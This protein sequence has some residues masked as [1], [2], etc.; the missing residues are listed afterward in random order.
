[1]AATESWARPRGRGSQQERVIPTV[2][3]VL[4]VPI[5]V[6]YVV[7]GVLSMVLGALYVP[8]GMFS[9]LSLDESAVLWTYGMAV[10][11]VAF[12]WLEY[13]LGKKILAGRRWAWLVGFV[14]QLPALV[15]FG[16]LQWWAPA[17]VARGLPSWRWW[18]ALPTVYCAVVLLLA[19][20]SDI[21]IRAYLRHRE[22]RDAR[23]AGGVAT[24]NA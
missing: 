10:A 3:K 11:L 8:L 20:L 13:Q 7:Q 6:I 24:G 19:I 16:T 12:G 1:M 2:I 5:G 14:L 15:A 9:V 18:L 23:A 4:I 21:L 17:E 22:R